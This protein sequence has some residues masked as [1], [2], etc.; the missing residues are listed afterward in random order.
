MF[1]YQ[2]FKDRDVDNIGWSGAFQDIVG[3]AGVIGREQGR[4]GYQNVDGNN[5]PPATPPSTE[6]PQNPGGNRGY[7][8]V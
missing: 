6:Q 8:A 7:Q 4:Q 1:L 3:P 5:P 2:L